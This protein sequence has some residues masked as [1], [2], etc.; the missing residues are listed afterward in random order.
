VSS[1][2]IGLGRR[3]NLEVVEERDTYRLFAA[4]GGHVYQ[5]SGNSREG[6]TR[7]TRGL[8]DAWVF[9]PAIGRAGW[10]EAKSVTGLIEW[11]RLVAL[12]RPPGRSKNAL[13][14]WLHAKEQAA[15]RDHCYQTG[16]LWGIGT[17]QDARDWLIS[18]GLARIEHGLFTLVRPRAEFDVTSVTVPPPFGKLDSIR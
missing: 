14:K 1:P 11:R 6:G 12:D 5:L 15:F 3:R 2:R 18:L 8:P 7:Q 4:A 17:L 10:W 13:Q 9:F 16:T